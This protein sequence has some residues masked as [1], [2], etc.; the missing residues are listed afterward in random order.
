M[1]LV[2]A[3]AEEAK[4][5][6]LTVPLPVAVPALDNPLE[7]ESPGGRVTELLAPV[8]VELVVVERAAAI[9]NGPKLE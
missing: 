7:V 6:G 5:E 8:A 4:L 1:E 3:P 2:V 9:E